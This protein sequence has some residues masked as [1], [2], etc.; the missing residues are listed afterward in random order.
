MRDRLRKPLAVVFG[1]LIVTATALGGAMV[2]NPEVDTLQEASGQYLGDAE[3][4]A[5]LVGGAILAYAAGHYTYTEYIKNQPNTEELQKTDALETKKAI[6]D[7]NSI[8]KTNNEQ[9][10]T[11]YGNYLNDT[12]TIALMEGKNAYIKA[13]ENGSAESVARN[14]ATEAVADY[15]AVKQQNLIASWNTSII[16]WNSSRHTAANTTDVSKS[17]ATFYHNQGSGNWS[18]SDHDIRYDGHTSASVQ[19]TNATSVDVEALDFYLRADGNS[20]GGVV[21]PATGGV[22]HNPHGFKVEVHGLQIQPPNDNYE[23]IRPMT[24]DDYSQKWA[25]IESQNDEVQGQLDTFINNTYESYQQ[26][27][28]NTSD[29]VDPYLGAREY[30]PET[31]ETWN[32]RTLASMGL[33]P[34]ENLSTIGVMNVTTD[35]ETVTGV[36]MTDNAPSGGFAINETYNATALNGSQWVAQTDGDVQK[37]S[38]NFT[39]TSAETSDGEAIEDGESITY[40]NIDYQT[41]DTEEF[42]ALQQQLDELTAEINARQQ[43]LRDGGGGVGWLPQGVSL[44]QVAP[45]AVAIGGALVLLGRN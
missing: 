22:S 13:L 3:G 23:R 16:V 35:D 36:L 31:S 1:L 5:L 6:Y 30:T 41:A 18:S 24:F 42:Q 11:T 28:I 44:G 39:I 26:G 38:G 14:R 4:G 40:R 8:Q 21:T 17:F 9:T 37:L 45:I 19:L 15:Y 12:Q 43:K 10:L 20:G 7:Q 27:D 25:E 34:P 33:S 32:L 29:L 2:F